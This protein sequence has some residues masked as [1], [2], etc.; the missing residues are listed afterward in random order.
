MRY[1][2]SDTNMDAVSQFFPQS[3]LGRGYPRTMRGRMQLSRLGIFDMLFPSD[4]SSASPY[5][6]TAPTSTGFDWT[7]L[8]G[9]LGDIYTAKTQA[10]LTKDL[11]QL[12]LERARQGLQPIA[13]SSVAPQVNVGVAPDVQ[14]TI[15]MVGLGG[16]VILGGAYAFG[17]IGKR[18]RR[19][20]RR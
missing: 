16:A 11:Y 1:S 6:S 14:R 2:R 15:L 4:I 12:N 10:D 9:T 13:A 19:A 8:F 17:V 7:G 18:G 20:R 5:E 3:F